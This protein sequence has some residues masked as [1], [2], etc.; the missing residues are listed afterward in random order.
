MRLI[1][2]KKATAKEAVKIQLTLIIS[3]AVVFIYSY[4]AP[5][6]YVIKFFSGNYSQSI[7]GCPILYVFGIPCPMC[8]MTRSL[9]A[10][11]D[12]DFARSMYYNP[13]SVVFYT[14]LVAAIISIF[15]LSIF[16][17]RFYIINHKAVIFIFVFSLAA[18]WLLNIFYGH[19]K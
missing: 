2:V 6:K 13:S 18:M 7:N 1:G 19:L 15:T 4:L 12:L 10:L 11:I 16:Q 17:Y 5:F 14:F 8:G 3:F 9:Y